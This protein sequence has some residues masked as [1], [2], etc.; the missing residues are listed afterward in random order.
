MPFH[1]T[2]GAASAVALTVSLTGCF[3]SE[4]SDDEVFEPSPRDAREIGNVVEMAMSLVGAA[5]GEIVSVERAGPAF[6][7]IYETDDAQLLEVAGTFDEAGPY[8][9]DVCRRL[10]QTCVELPVRFIWDEGPAQAAI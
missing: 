2:F 5:P 8:V 10:E 9:T 3:A 1:K 4:L 6:E 7:V